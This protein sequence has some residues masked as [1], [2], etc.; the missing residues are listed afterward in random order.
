MEQSPAKQAVFREI[1]HILEEN[2]MIDNDT[3][4]Q[5][6]VYFYVM[7]SEGDRLLSISAMCE[8]YKLDYGE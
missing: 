5:L 1:E 2:C 6:L 3:I 8:L 7:L 4:M